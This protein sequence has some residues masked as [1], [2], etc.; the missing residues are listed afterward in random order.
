MRIVAQRPHI[1][2]TQ[3]IMSH[4]I[5]LI[6]L[7]LGIGLGLGSGLLWHRMI[8]QSQ[9]VGLLREKVDSNKAGVHNIAATS[10]FVTKD[11]FTAKINSSPLPSRVLILPH[12]LIAKAFIKETLLAEA[13][14]QQPRT[15][16]IVGPDHLSTAASPIIS[17]NYAWQT[18]F[19]E[20]APNDNIINNLVKQKIASLEPEIFNS[21]HSVTSLVPFVHLAFPE[22]KIV[23]IIVQH[24]LT[25][26]Q[27]RALAKAL[28]QSDSLLI[29]SVD[30]SHYLPA[31]LAHIHDKKSLNT[32][33]RLDV[34]DVYNLEID[35]PDTLR[36]AMSIAQQNNAHNFHLYAHTNSQEF[37]GAEVTESTSH[38]IGGYNTDRTSKKSVL[39]MLAVGDMMFDRGV[40]EYSGELGPEYSFEKINGLEDRFFD[41]VDIVTG[42]LEGAISD[43]RAP[44]KAYDFAFDENVAQVLKAKNFDVVSLA[45]NHSLDQGELGYKS[46]VQSLTAVGIGSTGHQLSP[47]PVWYTT[48]DDQ[49]VA[50]V[51]VHATTSNYDKVAIKQTI[52]DAKNGADIVIV[53]A[54]WGNEYVE[55]PPLYVQNLATAMID[56][57]ADIIIGHHPHVMQGMTL[58]KNKP[59]FWSLGNFIF[60]QDWSP[61]TQQGLTIGLA[62]ENDKT[63]IALLPISIIKGQ[64]QLMRGAQKRTALSK[65]AA[66]SD[67]P[68]NLLESAKSGMLE[69]YK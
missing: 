62:I 50:M 52:I 64:P 34:T 39:T 37:T 58:Y 49:R 6:C 45:N 25:D 2:Y 11:Q 61:E 23:P 22:A 42:N 57:G 15:I 65:F 21:E 27:H 51:G 68:T 60:D 9:D 4:R 33:E 26:D 59:I 31:N 44:Q 18:P 43:R 48:I 30:F 5:L 29:A 28:N 32:L 3:N 63:T 24:N 19:G 40:R 12:H 1:K 36:L 14:L 35:S 13:K 55:R 54:H 69:I 7:L 47:L 46:T 67:L 17:T 20:M 53:Q 41:G 56:A 8:T 10:D 38:I 16:F 66:R